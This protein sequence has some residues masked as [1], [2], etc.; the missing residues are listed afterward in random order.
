MMLF[1]KIGLLCV[2]GFSAFVSRSQVME[3]KLIT[4]D[5]GDSILLKA[6][7]SN[8][9]TNGNYYFETLT[10]LST[11]KF[12]LTT[13]KKTYPACFTGSG[14]SIIPYKGLISD[15]F[16]A[17]STRKKIYFK[18][19]NGTRI[20]G[21]YAGKIREVLEF[22]R[23]NIA[24]ELCVGT[25]SFLYINDSLVNTIDSAKQLWQCNFSEN[26]NVIFSIFN[27]GLHKL[28][29][30]Y[31]LIDSAAQ[32]FSDIAVNNNRHYI[33]AKAQGGKF[34]LHTSKQT[35]GP[36]GIVEHSDLWNSNAYYFSGCADSQCYVLVNDKMYDKIPEAHTLIEDPASGGNVYKSDEMI[37]VTP[38]DAEH[39]IFSYNQQNK[40]GTFFNIN[41]KVTHFN[42]PFTSFIFTD[43]KGGYAFFGSRVDSVTGADM[44]FRNINGAES[45]IPLFTKRGPNH[46]QCLQLS[47]GGE[48]LHFIE[49]PDSVYL[50]RN[51]AL[52]CK[53]AART[54]F[55]TWD[56]SVLPQAHPEGVE[57]FQGVNIDG[58]SYLVYN[59]T[60]SKPL[61]VIY[62]EYDRI[63]APKK[64]SVVAGDVSSK[65]FFAIV[66]T[67]P[68]TYTLI[69][70]NK[71]YRELT[72]ID[73]IF[74]EASYF[75]DHAIIFY[76]TK[77]NGFYQ[78]KVNY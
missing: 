30:N 15:A 3:E 14:L 74:G 55:G 20:Y 5:A 59:N 44:T 26:G 21:P 42:Y 78:F 72:G 17:D 38:T 13:N 2:L 68:G 24:M 77:G 9:D 76:G 75:T 28:Y 61:P 70:N 58:S 12:Q 11:G 51:D 54:K 25:K 49:T 36:V 40:P 66:N 22:G 27:N 10:K 64:G 1:K 48:S 47:P 31:K 19:K 57:Y 18:N 60:I 35:F 6:F 71:D 16:F 23:E 4:K 8:F 37:T 46:M 34:Y 73:R 67:A 50:Y 33:Y 39:Y 69:I 56:A 45:R 65:G 32:P 62:P 52:L 53:P 43:K 63:S 29:V 41:G 7:R